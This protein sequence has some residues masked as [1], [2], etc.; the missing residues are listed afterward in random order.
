MWCINNCCCCYHALTLEL[1]V[2]H[3]I[4]HYTGF[5]PLLILNSPYVQIQRF[6]ITFR[7]PRAFSITLFKLLSIITIHIYRAVASSRSKYSSNS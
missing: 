2:H 6:N 5:V 4:Q 3:G 1:L 7:L